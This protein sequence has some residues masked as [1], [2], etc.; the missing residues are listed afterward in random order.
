[1]Q[2]CVIYTN[3]GL[4]EHAVSEIDSITVA[5]IDDGGDWGDP[6]QTQTILWRDGNMPATTS[7][8]SVANSSNPDGPDFRPYMDRVGKGNLTLSL[9]QNRT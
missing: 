9:S 8:E 1:M 3:E 5:E 4:S 7:R 6:S 2:P